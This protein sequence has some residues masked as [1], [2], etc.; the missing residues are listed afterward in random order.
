MV[1]GQ[2]AAH[3]VRRFAKIAWMT[4]RPTAVAILTMIVT[5]VG[6]TEAPAAGEPARRLTA[7][8]EVMRGDARRLADPALA[9]GHRDGLI[10]RIKGALSPLALLVGA[11]R[12]QSPGL[13]PLPPGLLEAA[14]DAVGGGGP[15][16][17]AASIEPLARLY[18]FRPG[19]ILPLDDRVAA[20]DSAAA[21]H[22]A[23]C[24][25]CHDEP[26]LGVER[27]AWNLPDLAKSMSVREF[28]ARMVIGVRGD[29]LTGM[30]NP[31]TDAEI[32][33]LIAYYRSA[34]P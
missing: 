32:S 30:E 24:A 4:Y 34:K 12:Q 6:V 2:D 16:L 19:S 29:R 11:A 31:L 27:P 33:R 1:G 18:S 22:A 28:A 5:V 25:A 15:A 20:T 9:A 8:I 26:N 3:A 7:E 10:A 13:P 23:Y 17:I 14:R 21:L